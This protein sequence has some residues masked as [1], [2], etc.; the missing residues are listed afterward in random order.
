[1]TIRKGSSIIAGSGP[2]DQVYDATSDHAQSGIAVASAVSSKANNSDVVHKSGNETIDG[3]KTI[4]SDLVRKMGG[5]DVTTAPLS[6]QYINW[7][8]PED[9]NGVYV[10][11]FGTS[12]YIDETLNSRLGVTRYVNGQPIY[13][14]VRASIRKDGTK[15]S[16][17]PP[18]DAV[19]SIVTTTGINKSE[20]GYVKLGNGLIVQWGTATCNSGNNNVSFP[21][22]FSN[23]NY[24]IVSNL[25]SSSNNLGAGAANSIYNKSTTG[26]IIQVRAFP[27]VG[28][29]A[30]SSEWLAIGY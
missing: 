25:I 5:L 15:S 11:F 9:E 13:T 6:D 20:N 22:A 8:S 30:A 3:F 19:D 2:V 24:R 29:G 14:E 16:Y 21:T 17:A 18:S 10:G 7:I 12:Y 23:T 4:T 1:M 26:C 28:I 27:G